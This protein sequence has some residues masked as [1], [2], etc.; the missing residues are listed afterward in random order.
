M[1][2]PDEATIADYEDAQGE[3]ARFFWAAEQSVYDS[4]PDPDEFYDD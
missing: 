1:I 3:D 2:E 4:E